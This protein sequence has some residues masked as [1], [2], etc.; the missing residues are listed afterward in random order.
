[1]TIATEFLLR[2]LRRVLP[3]RDPRLYA[4]CKRYVDRFNGENDGEMRS[5]G[6]LLFMKKNLPG[7]RIVFDIG[8]NIGQWS[9]LAL[10]L[11]PAIEL[12][13]F[14]PSQ[15]FN[16]L[17]ARFQSHPNVVC[18][19]IGMGE[20]PGESRLWLF[21]QNS[22]LNSLYRRTGLEG[23][24]L[25]RPARSELIRMETVDR[26]CATRRID[27]I[28][29]CKVDVEGHELAV[30][31]GMR[32]MLSSGRVKI[33]QFEYGGTFIDARVLLKDFFEFFA[34]LPYRLHKIY[35]DRARSVPRY[36][37]SLENFQYQNWVSVAWDH[38]VR[39]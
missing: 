36:S 4:F 6:E 14:E 23:L 18:N 9:Y 20:E 12:H 25:A 34:D 13:C 38:R 37:Q 22:G 11:N 31:K 15:S 16:I 24:G 5:N 1:M 30:L 19:R 33:I 21:D 10:Q 7:R 39:M 8:A 3:P 2:F 35:P 17:S 26:Y 28:D 32:K 27:T 29:Y